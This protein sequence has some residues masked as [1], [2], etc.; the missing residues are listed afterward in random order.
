L[1]FP[2]RVEDFTRPV[3]NRQR[4]VLLGMFQITPIGRAM[5]INPDSPIGSQLLTDKKVAERF[6]VSVRTVIDWRN[7]GK[8]PFIRLGRSIRYRR[9]SIDA[10]LEK[11]EISGVR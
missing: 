3:L 6:N 1:V 7:A 5:Q 10:L 4:V 2:P 11:L 9:E 8:I